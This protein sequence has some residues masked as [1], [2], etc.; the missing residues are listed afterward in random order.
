MT[1]QPWHESVA[2]RIATALVADIGDCREF[3]NKRHMAA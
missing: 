3:R 1:T 2:P